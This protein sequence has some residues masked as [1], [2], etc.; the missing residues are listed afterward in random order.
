MGVGRR[1]KKEG[2]AV[3]VRINC[4]VRTTSKDTAAATSKPNKS[5][6]ALS[7]RAESEKY[8]RSKRKDL[9][10]FLFLSPAVYTRVETPC[11]MRRGRIIKIYFCVGG[12]SWGK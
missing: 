11:Q 8:E 3:A 5:L 10:S 12:E 6:E 2:A 1:G 4:K 7:P 9:R